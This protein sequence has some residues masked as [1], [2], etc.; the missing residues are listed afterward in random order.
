M[1]ERCARTFDEALLSGCVN[2][3]GANA[4]IDVPLHDVDGD[5]RG[6][7]VAGVRH[8][9]GRR[10]RAL[11][12]APGRVPGSFASIGRKHATGFETEEAGKISKKVAAELSRRDVNP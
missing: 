12:Q 7:R 10:A 3:L 11:S 8:G 1:P 6:R 5:A 9:G 4:I 2:G